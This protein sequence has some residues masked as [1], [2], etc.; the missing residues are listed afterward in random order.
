DGEYNVVTT[1]VV[2]N[3]SLT[4]DEISVLKNKIR[5]KLKTL[6]IQHATIEFETKNESC[7]FENCSH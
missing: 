5:D 1:H 7:C 4:L 2:L 6:N 3:K